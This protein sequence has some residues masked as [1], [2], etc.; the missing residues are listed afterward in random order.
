MSAPPFEL[1]YTDEAQGVID[2]LDG[3]MYADK[4]KKVVKALRLLRDIGPAHP[5]LHSHKYQSLQGPNREDVWESYIENHTPSA[6]RIWWVY[7]PN[8]DMLTI[9]TIGPHP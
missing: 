8:T 5:G 3:K 2:A 6:W 7:G 4:R 1:R 9:V